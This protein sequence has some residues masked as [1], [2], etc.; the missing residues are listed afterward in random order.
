MSFSADSCLARS[1]LRQKYSDRQLL[2]IY[3]E[4][5]SH[6]DVLTKRDWLSVFRHVEASSSFTSRICWS[7]HRI[8]F[9]ASDQ[10]RCL[11]GA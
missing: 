5:A 10:F 2:R 6:E 11:A 4:L 7:E 9:D 8:F 3:S 1:P